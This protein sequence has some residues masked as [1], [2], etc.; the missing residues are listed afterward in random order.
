[1]NIGFVDTHAH[2]YDKSFEQDI[3]D[4]D[5]IEIDKKVAKYNLMFFIKFMSFDF[6]IE[7]L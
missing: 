7:Q 3:N 6:R 5:K 1:M 2:L 4:A